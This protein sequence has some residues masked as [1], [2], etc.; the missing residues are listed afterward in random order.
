MMTK[1]WSFSPNDRPRFSE[2]VH[3]IQDM[4]TVLE[5]Q[6]KQGQHTADINNTYVNTDTCTDYHYHD[7]TDEKETLA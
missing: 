6:M 2:L 7:N 5:Q 1:C 4:I 3:E